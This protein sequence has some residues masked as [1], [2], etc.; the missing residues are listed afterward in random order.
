MGGGRNKT[1]Q[2]EPQWTVSDSWC[3]STSGF[4]Y[5]RERETKKGVTVFAGI[6][7][8]YQ[9]ET[10]LLLHSRPAGIHVACRPAPGCVLL[11]PWSPVTS[12]GQM[13]QSWPEKGMVTS[14]SDP[15]AM[16]LCVLPLCGPLRP[17]QV[18]FEREG[19]RESRN[20]EEGCVS[21][22]KSWL[23]HLVA[24]TGQ[25]TVIFYFSFRICKMGKWNLL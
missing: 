2:Q 22:F 21:V 9:E 12:H 7:D 13:Q 1:T 25:M 16:R 8:W 15:S 19:S 4:L 14:R 3:L 18:G 23:L 5:F 17:A 20:V 6:T 11:L 24:M 10:G